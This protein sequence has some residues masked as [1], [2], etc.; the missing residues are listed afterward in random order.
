M[1]AV[2]K[3]DGAKGEVVVDAVEG[4]DVWDGIGQESEGFGT[5]EGGGFLM[6]EGVYVLE[7]EGA[8]FG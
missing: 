4:R 1:H 2:L 8:E 7:G 5:G 3:G 6:I